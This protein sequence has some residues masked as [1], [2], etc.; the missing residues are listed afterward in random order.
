MIPRSLRETENWQ[1]AG[2][3]HIH[4]S[5]NGRERIYNYKLPKVNVL[6][7][8]EIRGPESR[9]NLNKVS[10]AKENDKVILVTTVWGERW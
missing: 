9:R 4:A 1:E 6:I 10:Q 7:E 3:K 2:R 5:Q 8:K